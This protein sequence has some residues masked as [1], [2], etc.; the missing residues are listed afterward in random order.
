MTWVSLTIMI[1]ALVL[2]AA[3]L[4]GWRGDAL[5]IPV[6]AIGTFAF[7][8]VVQPVQ[9]L[10]SGTYSLFLT[11]WQMSEGLLVSAL[12][13]F[14]FMCGWLYPSRSTQTVGAP[15]DRRAMWS[16]GFGAA[17]I[18]LIL[19]VVFIERSGGIAASYSLAHGHA[20]AW[21]ENTAYLYDGPWLMLSGSSMMIFAYPK[22][23]TRRWMM[24]T[25]YG[26]LTVFLA[27]AIMGGSRAGL[28]GV[29]SVAF[30]SNAIVRR[31][32]VQAWQAF[33]LLFAAGCVIT[34]V[35]VNRDRIHLGPHS[36]REVESSS[37]AFDDLVGPSES[38]QEHDTT[39]QEFLYHAVQLNTVNETGKLDYGL[40]WI[41]FL[42]INPIPKLLWPEKA[43]PPP[44]GVTWEDIK[45]HTSLTI[46]AGSAPG[47]VAN[48]YA[49]FGLASV[50]FFF[51]LGSAL[52]RLF[53]AA[54]NLS[55]SATAV[56]YVMI[57]AAS[58]NMFAQG[59]DAIFVSLGYSMAPVL[60]FSWLARES[61]R[62]ARERQRRLIL[63]QVAAQCQQPAALRG[64]Q[65][66]SLRS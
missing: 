37:Q 32:R 10:W 5:G 54:C 12:M 11:D 1:C 60:L 28:F 66:S 22:S 34:I 25:P 56:G 35:F 46:A 19:H 41:E 61:K 36:S 45:E 44:R 29:I 63:S 31:W 20:M 58:L 59:F 48:I 13:L 55:S 52:R 30:V 64:E 14:C 51:G 15:W 21:R 40:P 26:F 38:D 27:N 4:R 3:C 33:V 24:Y 57:Y 8:Y 65:W 2:S 62:K 17:F 47:I 18:G 39:A 6:V 43:F 53:I 7:L 9:L 16:F 42:V 50:L 23:R 49:R